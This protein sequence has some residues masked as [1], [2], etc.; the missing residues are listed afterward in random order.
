M[1]EGV[2]VAGGA[3]RTSSGE[4]MRTTK[5]AKAGH[6]TSERSRAAHARTK[7]T[8]AQHQRRVLAPAASAPHM[9]GAVLLVGGPRRLT[10]RARRTKTP[11]SGLQCAHAHPAGRNGTPR[12]PRGRRGRVARAPRAPARWP[13]RRLGGVGGRAAPGR[14]WSGEH[15]GGLTF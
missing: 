6:N 14:R 9:R 5:Q 12:G 4:Y 13:R 8:R 11:K 15:E 3:G 2:G 10:E 7:R 1:F